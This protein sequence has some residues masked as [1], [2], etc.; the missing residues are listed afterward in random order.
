MGRRRY[1][2]EFLLEAGR[3]AIAQYGERLTQFDFCR[4][5][6]VSAIVIRDRFGGWLAFRERLGLSPRRLLGTRLRQH[7][8]E[9]IIEKLEWAARKRGVDITLEEF[10]QLTGISSATVYRYF[11]GWPDLRTCADLPTDGKP[12]KCY[13]DDALL[14]QVHRVAQLVGRMPTVEDFKQYGHAATSTLRKRFGPE[15]KWVQL[16]YEKWL[17]WRAVMGKRGAVRD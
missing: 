8:R 12:K 5:T 2:D 17:E 4:E 6:G 16:R 15:W 13:S 3:E 9:A 14:Q 10:A 11:R 7:S 1:T